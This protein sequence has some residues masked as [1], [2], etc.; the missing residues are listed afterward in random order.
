LSPDF[1]QRLQEKGR[2]IA[3]SDGQIIISI[4]GKT[5][6]GAVRRGETK[7]HVHIVNAAMGLIVMAKKMVG[8]KTDD[9]PVAH[10]AHKGD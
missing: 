2:G 8:E 1:I 9:I 4:D 6:R 5:S 7:S 10:R 3:K